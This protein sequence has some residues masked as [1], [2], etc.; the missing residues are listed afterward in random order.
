MQDYWWDETFLDFNNFS[1]RQKKNLSNISKTPDELF[2]KYIKNKNIEKLAIDIERALETT[3]NYA[4]YFSLR[5]LNYFENFWD[6]NKKENNNSE[7]NSPNITT[8]KEAISEKVFSCLNFY[9]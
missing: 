6:E 8:S 1:E 5:I 7:F 3:S 2:E 4:T 9:F